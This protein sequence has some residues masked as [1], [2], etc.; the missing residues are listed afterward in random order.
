MLGLLAAV[1]TSGTGKGT[2]G[3]RVTKPTTSTSG[4]HEAEQNVPLPAELPASLSEHH[5]I[6]IMISPCILRASTISSSMCDVAEAFLFR[7]NSAEDAFFVLVRNT[8]VVYVSN[9]R[10]RVRSTFGHAVF[11]G[12]SC[13]SGSI[14]R[15]KATA[16]PISL[17]SNC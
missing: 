14:V 15:T 7:C 4:V 9:F 17:S 3:A 13:S 10:I 2:C 11:S 12:A 1:P 5:T 16:A 6:T 8:A